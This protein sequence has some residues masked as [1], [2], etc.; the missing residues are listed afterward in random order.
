M[1]KL[2]VSVTVLAAMGLLGMQALA[3]VAPATYLPTINPANAP[4]GTHLQTGTISCIVG[5]DLSITCGSYELAG[6]GNANASVLLTASYSATVDCTNKG[7][8]LVPVKSQGVPASDGDADL[9]PKNG[10]LAVPAVSVGVPEEQAFFDEATCPN[11]N[12]T[13]SLAPGDP[14]LDSFTYTLTF[15]G[16]ANPY[17]TISAP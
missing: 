9:E 7:G 5:V 12:W 13:K 2:L 10:R 17:I 16:F 1:K 8:K 14:T 6:V 15:G 4:S 3:A 11:G